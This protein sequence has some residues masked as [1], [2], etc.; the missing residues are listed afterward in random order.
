M[1]GQLLMKGGTLKRLFV[2]MLVVFA[3]DGNSVAAEQPIS[4]TQRTGADVFDQLQQQLDKDACH[5]NDASNKWLK[6]YIKT[7]REFTNHLKAILPLLDY[8][9]N[10]AKEKKLPAEFVLVPFIESWYEPAASTKS[11]PIG[12]WQMMPNT[13]KHFGI[14]FGN[15]YDGRYS[16]VDSTEAALNYLKKLQHEFKH[17]PTALMAYN[18]GDS[19]MRS[20]LKRQKLNR[21][22]AAQKLPTGLKAHTYAYIHKIEAISCLLNQPKRFGITLPDKARFTP[23]T[24]IDVDNSRQSLQQLA[25]SAQMSLSELVTLN[26][27]YRNGLKDNAPNRI[28]VLRHT[29]TDN[30][31]PLDSGN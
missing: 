5:Q 12:L 16:P 9:S 10:E 26:P 13:A 8:V 15:G 14:R 25:D 28:L 20:S 1:E 18:A 29:N 31:V 2:T 27:S 30:N 22:D 7:P 6:R 23:L 19:R 17:W 11:G 24:V 21:A 4:A 3:Y